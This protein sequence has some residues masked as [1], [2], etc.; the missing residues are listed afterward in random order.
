MILYVLTFFLTFSLH[1]LGAVDIKL[2][3]STKQVLL[4]EPF[5][6]KA[7]VTSSDTQSKNIHINGLDKLDVLSE[8][9]SQ[10][11][12][13]IN[14]R[15]RSKTVHTFSVSANKEEA[16][17]L[18]PATVELDGNK[19][20]SNTIKLNISK[21]S[22]PMSQSKKI[23][24][25]IF[26]E[27]SLDKTKLVI[28]EIGVLTFKIYYKDGIRVLGMDPPDSSGFTLKELNTFNRVEEIQGK[29]FNVLEKQFLLTPLKVGAGNIKSIKTVYARPVRL[30]GGFGMFGT[31]YEQKISYSNGLTVDVD[32]LPILSEKVNGVGNFSK[33]NVTVSEQNINTNEPV[34]LVATVHGKGNL[35]QVETPKLKL[36]DSFKCYD[37]KSSSEYDINTGQGKKTFEYVLQVKDPGKCEIPSQKFAYYDVDSKEVKSLYSDTVKLNIRADATQIMHPVEQPKKVAV[38][39]QAKNPKDDIHFIEEDGPLFTGSENGIN[40]W[41]FLFL[42]FLPIVLFIGRSAGVSYGYLKQRVINLIWPHKPLDAANS[43]LKRLEKEGDLEGLYQFLL[44]Y[45][46]DK[47]T[48]SN[49]VIGED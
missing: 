45:L 20:V 12:S 34:K 17:A 22:I 25:N 24:K 43:V 1:I 29:H 36:S 32:N 26:T 15:I 6:V 33:F 44:G 14:G 47:F 48:V 41:V 42:V 19:V 21:D 5:Q 11:I 39:L 40:I 49:S 27:L 2:E 46:S 4:N 7:T 8:S 37:S 28:G 38:N 10:S 30:G 9:A 16:L 3:T 23:T 13:L 31:H 18:G 35:D